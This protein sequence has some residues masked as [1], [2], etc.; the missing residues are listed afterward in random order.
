MA[1]A[2]ALRAEYQRIRALQPEEKPRC[3]TCKCAKRTHRRGY[4]NCNKKGCTCTRYERDSDGYARFMAAY[5][6]WAKQAQAAGVPV[7]VFRFATLDAAMR[8][9]MQEPVN[10]KNREEWRRFMDGSTK[11]EAFIPRYLGD[12]WDAGVRNLPDLCKWL[13][14]GWPQGVVKMRDGIGKLK[15]PKLADVRRRGRWSDVGDVLSLDRLYGGNVDRC[16]RTTHRANCGAP[17]RLQ[18]I[19]QGALYSGDLDDLFWRGVPAAAL[20]DAATSAGYQVAV[21]TVRAVANYTQ[22]RATYIGVT[23]VKNY[24]APLNLSVM[25]A[26]IAT[27]SV[28]MGVTW[29]HRAQCAID[30]VRLPGGVYQP[31]LEELRARGCVDRGALVLVVPA[32]TLSEGA[33]REWLGEALARLARIADGKEAA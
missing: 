8:A 24:D 29:A 15:V 1:D 23:R 18:I 2:E 16:W 4:F 30:R 31:D 3:A 12:A 21:D 26:A 17:P 32:T 27:A 7:D 6:V 22:G 14:A 10:P 5:D 11:H 20:C 33:A 9:A 25:M 19:M 28:H 13:G